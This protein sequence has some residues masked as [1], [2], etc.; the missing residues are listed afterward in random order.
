MENK[1]KCAFVGLGRIASLL[2]DDTLREKPCTHA[3]AVSQ[4]PDCII[5][6]GCDTKEER[7]N[8]FKEK[9]GCPVFQDM[10]RLIEETKP[11]IFFIATHP[12][13]HLEI[14]QIAIAHGIA[15]IVC[16]KPLADTL[17]KAKK[18][19]SYHEK[20]LSKIIINHERRYSAN[21]ILAKKHIDEKT[22]GKL[23]S[24]S[25]NLYMGKKTRIIDV[26]WHDGTHMA[27]AIMYLSGGILKKKKI[28]GNLRKK[29]GTA[30][31]AAEVNGS[32]GKIPVLIECGA[33]RDYLAFSFELSFESGM[34]RIG[35]GIYE[36]YKSAE[37]PY[38]EN[39]N[40]LIKCDTPKFEKTG[41]FENMIKDAVKATKEPY[42]QP[43]ST[44]ADGFKAVKFL[45]SL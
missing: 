34:I 43:L 26:L 20:K 28:T 27:D 44:A 16:E 40:S 2:E 30:F 35:N 6:G 11:D 10:D 23:L 9:W 19:V 4:N 22:Y 5:V 13:T 3:G 24:I 42:Y 15:V 39:F 18:I 21:Y 36:E 38:Y 7:R 41:Y 25:A 14:A 32:H 12:D 8:L 33:G 1:F 17:K 31:I 45:S 37:S 29:T